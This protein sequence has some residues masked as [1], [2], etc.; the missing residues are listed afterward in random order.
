MSFSGWLTLGLT[1]LVLLT[2]I[3]TKI[4]P[5]VVMLAALTILSVSGILT[6]SEALAGFSNSGLITVAAMFVVAAG[7]HHSGGIDILVNK[8]LG[9]PKNL[10]AALLRIFIPVV[11][12]SAFLNN[13]PVVATMIPA[14]MAWSKKND[15]A[16]SRLLIPLSYT[17]ILGGTITLIGTSTNLVVNGQYQSITGNPGFGLFDITLIGLPIAILGMVF[18]YFISP[19]LL[20]NKRESKPFS[21]LREFTLEVCISNNG[22]LVGKSIA[23]AGLRNLKRIY[24]VEIERDNTTLSAV[25]SDEILYGNDRLVFAG[26][27]EAITDLL[28]INGI[29]APLNQDKSS[30]DEKKSGRTLV[31][32]V[33][34]PHCEA[35]G[36]AIRDSKFRNRYGAVVLAVARNGE[37]LKSNLGGIKIQAGDTLLLEAR[38]AFISRQ[39][40][41]KDFLLVNVL[42]HEQPN[43]EKANLSWGILVCAVLS[44]AFGI[45]SMLNAALVG[46]GLMLAMGCLSVKQAEK[47][48]DLTVIL[49]IA[50]SFSLGLALQKTGVASFIA[51]NIVNISAGNALL[52]LILT[53]VTVS[54]LT[55]VITN[56]A[57]AV[58]ILPIIIEITDKAALNAEPYIFAIMMAASASF[59]TPLGYQTNLMVLGPGNYKFNDFLKIGLPMNLFIGTAT[60]SILYLFWPL[61]LA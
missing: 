44:A 20:P 1:L 25:S 17:A 27:T 35:L 30:L 29:E 8:L 49:T 52:L 12:L 10:R 21:D 13:T 46:A 19:F 11:P 51:D 43:H 24:L 56:N 48:L 60:V 4:A 23:E 6:T 15:L 40:Y 38:P 16:P 57:A 22:P 61:T 5:H 54:I 53:Y 39:K 26:Q 47:S 2:L 34:S 31:E 37:R 9:S 32:V 50:A 41:N 18:I 59:A 14:I 45:T 28:K 33:V 36:S 55:E 3:R 42:D 58:L 7:I